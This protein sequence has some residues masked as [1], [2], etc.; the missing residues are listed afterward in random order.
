MSTTA[1]ELL[2][3]M[4]VRLAMQEAGT[5]CPSPS[6]AAATKRLVAHLAVLSPNEEIRIEYTSPPIRAQ[7]I[8]QST[9]EVL[10]ELWER[11][12]T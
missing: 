9:N 12:E 7:Y 8:R 3:I 2:S 11:N 6:V 4:K 5:I 1:Q 10:A